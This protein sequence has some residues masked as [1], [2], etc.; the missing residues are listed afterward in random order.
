VTTATS[1]RAD[2]HDN[3]ER[4]LEAA[5]EIIAERGPEALSVSEVARRAGLNRTTAHTHF[6]TRADL[7]LTVKQHYQRHT[8]EMLSASK[9]LDEWIDH[10][11][12]KLVENPAMHRFAVHDLLDGSTPNREGW[13]E[14]T[15]WMEQVAKEQGRAKGP[16][17][18]F[19]A[20]FLIAIVYLW[21]LLARIHYDEP[22]RPAARE[23][24]ASEIKRL[25]LYGFIDPKRAP[26]MVS[27][28]TGSE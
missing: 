6:A 7:V 27:A 12:E 16:S 2:F 26:A 10:L 4:L 21:P 25:L 22:E 23:R 13:Q 18:E 20:P 8:V 17:A 24:L 19:M 1:R 11:V 9:P 3:R 28:L 14:Y 15:A 5:R